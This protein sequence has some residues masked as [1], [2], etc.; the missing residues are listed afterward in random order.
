MVLWGLRLVCFA[1]PMIGVRPTP[2]QEEHGTESEKMESGSDRSADGNCPEVVLS[3]W[4]SKT[5]SCV[6]IS[7][8]RDGK[9]W[10]GIFR[11][12][13]LFAFH[14]WNVKTYLLFHAK[15]SMRYLCFFRREG[16]KEQEGGMALKI[17]DLNPLC[18][19]LFWATGSDPPLREPACCL[20]MDPKETALHPPSCLLLQEAS[21]CA[22]PGF[23]S[24]QAS[25]TGKAEL[26]WVLGQGGQKHR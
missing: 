11:T 26:S 15:M 13:Y 16:L 2:Q 4:R 21:P 12:V 23:R 19:Q 18:S 8:K 24:K 22:L 10:R 1:H 7:R 14:D 17:P 3:H 20:Y 9:L 25:V 6:L 5:E